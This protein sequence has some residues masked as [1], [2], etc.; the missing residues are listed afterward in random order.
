MKTT[1]KI[2]NGYVWEG[3][4][5]YEDIPIS[6]VISQDDITDISGSAFKY[7]KTFTV[8]GTKHNNQIFEGFYSVIGTDF[9]PLTKL[10]CVVEN[11]GNVIFEGF[12][13]LNAVIFTGD[14]IEYEVYIL[15]ALSDFSSEIQPLQ[16]KD[17]DFQD[18]DHEN[19]YDNIVQSWEY[20]GGTSG[21]F[22][23]Q[24]LYPFYNYG[25]P[26][27][28]NDNPTFEFTLT[29]TNTFTTSA[30][31]VPE[32]YFKPSI[33]LKSLVD[34]IFSATS[35]SYT[36]TFFDSDYFKSI[37]M[38][39][40]DNGEIGVTRQEEDTQNR[41]IFKVYANYTLVYD[42][43]P[44]DLMK[45]I[46]FSTLDPDG[47]DP[48]GS[49][50]LDDDMPG[51]SND[52]YRNY[53]NVPTAG[54]YYFNM[55]FRYLNNSGYNYP[56]YFRIKIYKSTNPNNIGGGTLVYQTPGSGFAALASAQE[57]NVFFSGALQSNE[58]VSAY[59]EIIDTA[60]F[61]NGGVRLI[62]PN[63]VGNM[64]WDLY[65]S[66][67]LLGSTNVNMKLQMPDMSV[68]D[69]FQSLV[70]MF[71]L[72]I[73]KDDFDKVLKIE[74]W[75][76]YYDDSTRAVSDW[77]QLIDRSSSIRV[78]PLDFTL[79]KDLIF[80]YSSAGDEVLGKYYEDNYNN[81]FGTR[82]YSSPSNIL[83]GEQTIELP[84]SPFPT[85]TIDGSEYIIMGQ[86]FKRDDNGLQQPYAGNPHIYFWVGNRYMY[87][88]QFGGGVNQWYL[89]SGATQVPLNTYPAV[90]HLSRLG[91]F[92]S[93]ELS[94]LNY[95]PQWDFFQ[96]YNSVVHPWSNYS[97]YTSWWEDYVN[98]IYSP[99][100]RR[101]SG[102]FLLHPQDI[103]EI[104][105]ND[106]IYVKDNFWR[107]EKIT[108]ADLVNPKLVE[109]SLLKEVGGF[110]DKDPVA[111]VY[112]L[113]PNANYPTS[114]PSTLNW[115]FENLLGSY[116]GNIEFPEFTIIQQSTSNQLLY[117]TSYGS[118]SFSFYPGNL[119]FIVGFNYANNLGSINNLE[120][121]LGTSS[122]DD[123]YGRLAI[124][125][126]GDNNY[127]ELDVTDYI[128]ASGNVYAT[129]DTY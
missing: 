66:P 50:T 32:E 45:P 69:F 129:I 25:L 12:L 2:K 86:T 47:Y 67:S 65:T 99:E 59:M 101:M 40:S 83:T 38:S 112:E 31:A 75:N 26:Y 114:P 62:G 57:A 14:Y 9:D 41:N 52:D 64:W 117:T 92:E 10:E 6:A 60:G 61:P 11:G 91:N 77:T 108:D 87:S 48:L 124:P 102:R 88:T 82:R 44:N 95:Q 72:T 33:Q 30:N 23:G 74:P 128:P 8:P 84:F 63:G 120:I 34:R 36:S 13:R 17:L 49:W 94:D 81:I 68:S 116:A 70:S 28:S 78:E 1:L 90:H 16:L 37:Y 105:L 113:E 106:K 35:Y 119:R 96:S 109:V 29:G 53:F 107:I 5:I 43:D 97:L 111:P 121:T 58:Y 15:T 76:T 27:D 100:S 122:G 4:D 51:F 79:S 56:T 104:K 98:S 22:E 71:N 7:S 80:T 24:V 89:T 19:N 42:Y 18:L 123:S 115:Y 54:D 20:T 21:L 110:Y 39:L 126:P 85:N 127:Y 55:R 46:P 118:G 125:Q 3:I 103:G 73:E 93:N